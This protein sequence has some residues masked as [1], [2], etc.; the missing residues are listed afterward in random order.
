[1]SNMKPW[2][3][4]LFPGEISDYVTKK[5]ISAEEAAYILLKQNVEV[6]GDLIRGYA[7]FIDV[8]RP[9]LKLK[10]YPPKN[11]KNYELFKKF[12]R[13]AKKDMKTK[14]KISEKTLEIIKK[15]E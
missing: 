1:M 5:R 7:Y 2:K 6:A 12:Y 15:G 14:G 10:S 13:A 11:K 4:R 9:K 8:T 3:S